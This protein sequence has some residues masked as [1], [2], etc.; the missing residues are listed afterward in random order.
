MILSSVSHWLRIARNHGESR[1]LPKPKV[2]GS[3]P[4]VRFPRLS[5]QFPDLPAAAGIWDLLF[6]RAYSDLV[7]APRDPSPICLP[8]RRST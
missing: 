8:S 1:R 2:A 6:G 4:V 5:S 3:R 7:G